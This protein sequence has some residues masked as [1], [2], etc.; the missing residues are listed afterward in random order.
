MLDPPE[1]SRRP[2]LAGL[3]PPAAASSVSFA[4]AS[5]SLPMK[6]S[7]RMNVFA[8]VFDDGTR[9]SSC[10]LIVLPPAVDPKNENWF[11]A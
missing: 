1:L 6:A 11:M 4:I 2:I 9:S 7:C 5:P 3:P 10:Q 8:S